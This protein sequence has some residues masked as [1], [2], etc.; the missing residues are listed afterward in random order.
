VRKFV[1]QRELTVIL[2]VDASGSG[3]S[4]RAR[5]SSS[6]AAQVAATIAFSAV[7][8]TTRSGS[9][10]SRQVERFV[11]PRKGKQ[12][13]L[14]L[15]RDICFRAAASAARHRPRR[16]EFV[17]RILKHRAIV[18][19]IKRFSGAG[20]RGGQRCGFTRARSPAGT[21]WS[22]FRSPTAPSRAAASGS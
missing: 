5:S 4:A 20:L 15:V 14:R 6:R 19:L 7:S 2:C 12:H 18:F 13:V 22:R 8:N 3:Y 16:F 9:C 10:S 1:E 17:M 11:P 21:T